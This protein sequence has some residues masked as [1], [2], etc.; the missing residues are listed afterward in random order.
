M[1]EKEGFNEKE[2]TA[3]WDG[4][5]ESLGGEL[6][7]EKVAVFCAR[8][9]DEAV[10]QRFKQE[11]IKLG[12]EVNLISQ[13]KAT[14]GSTQ[15]GLYSEFK[16][17]TATVI[18]APEFREFPCDDENLVILE[19]VKLIATNPTES[20]K[21]VAFSPNH[22]RQS[23][24]FIGKVRGGYVK[25]GELNDGKMFAEKLLRAIYS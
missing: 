17:A 3:F 8:N 10:G 13:K 6:E 15:W 22:T 2:M 12:A 23:Y 21:A 25:L 1:S 14:G 20:Y 16:E 18:I 11:F 7:G 19:A 5:S 24:G 9:R 4:V